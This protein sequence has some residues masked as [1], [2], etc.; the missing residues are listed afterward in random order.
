MCQPVSRRRLGRA[1]V[2]PGHEIIIAPSFTRLGQLLDGVG[3]YISTSYNVF[4]SQLATSRSQQEVRD[5]GMCYET[6]CVCVWGGLNSVHSANRAQKEEGTLAHEKLTA[7]DNGAGAARWRSLTSPI[8][9]SS[10]SRS[11]GKIIILTPLLP[12]TREAFL[13]NASTMG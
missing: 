8:V 3:I 9:T 10:A 1:F 13:K 6:V 4:F 7:R 5:D 11:W 12:H 2:T